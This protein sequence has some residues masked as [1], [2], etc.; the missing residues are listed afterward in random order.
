MNTTPDYRFRDVQENV[1]H[2]FGFLFERGFHIVSIIFVDREMEH[3]SVIMASNKCLIKIFNDQDE[4]MLAIS[5]L[6][7]YHE[8]GFFDLEEL[9]YLASR[10]ERYPGRY[11]TSTLTEEQQF[12]RLANLLKDYIDHIV[13][14]PG[15][16]LYGDEDELRKTLM[17][18][19]GAMTRDNR[20]EK[21][22]FYF[23]DL[24]HES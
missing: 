21:I 4:I 7:I 5:T 12:E 20:L 10:G 19:R 3:W 18:I 15:E 23:Q 13:F 17:Q 11:L 6:Q 22:W 8:A 24:L 14:L 1:R 2:H 9:A 16:N